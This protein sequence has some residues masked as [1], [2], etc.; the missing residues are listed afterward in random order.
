MYIRS[1]I[2][3]SVILGRDDGQRLHSWPQADMICEHATALIHKRNPGQCGPRRSRW[4]GKEPAEGSGV[5]L[6]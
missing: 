2:R 1:Y 6:L 3:Y 5:F 4:Q